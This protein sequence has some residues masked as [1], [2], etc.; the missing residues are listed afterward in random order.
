MKPSRLGQLIADQQEYLSK[1]Q[2]RKESIEKKM[3]EC[4]RKIDEYSLL[5]NN[6][7]YN[8]MADALMDAGIA[9]DDVIAVLSSGGMP[10]LLKLISPPAADD[11]PRDA[12]VMNLDVEEACG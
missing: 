8:I 7:Q 3:K 10:A 4:Q 5:K 12:P 9:F 1:L 11:A 6:A 2:S